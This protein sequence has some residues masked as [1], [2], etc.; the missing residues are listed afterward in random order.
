MENERTKSVRPI[1]IQVMRKSIEILTLLRFY[2][3]KIL[4]SI[5]E[6]VD[7]CTLF[8][9][10]SALKIK[11]VGKI[12]VQMEMRGRKILCHAVTITDLRTQMNLAVIFKKRF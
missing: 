1:T 4:Y 6:L 12:G 7:C 11:V 2:Q 3:L 5:C 9:S 10:F 8:V